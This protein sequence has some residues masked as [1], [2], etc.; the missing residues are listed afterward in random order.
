MP[1]GVQFNENYPNISKSLEI[2]EKAQKIMTPVTQTMAKGPGQYS[3]GASPVYL[4]KGDGSHV[5]DVDGN[6]Y[7]DWNAAIGP[8]S[9]GYCYPAVDNAIKRQ[10]EDGITFR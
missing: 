8:L 3:I 7:L 2:Y 5:W 4:K 1:N 6:E 9:L 10:L